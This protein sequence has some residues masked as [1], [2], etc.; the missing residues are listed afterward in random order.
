M[1][2]QIVLL[3]K[4]R[5]SLLDLDNTKMN[6]HANTHHDKKYNLHLELGKCVYIIYKGFPT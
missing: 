5:G 6:P 2:S 3:L 4:I 1:S